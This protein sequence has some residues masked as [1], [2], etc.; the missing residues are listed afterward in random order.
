MRIVAMLL[1]LAGVAGPLAAQELAADTASPLSLREVVSSALATH[2]AVAGAKAQLASAEASVGEAKSALLPALSATA[3]LTRYQKPMIVAPLHALNVQHLPVFE[4]TLYEAHAAL[5][6]TIFDG[7]ARGAQI[8]AAE[9]VARSA[10]AGVAVSS[11]SVIAETV[12]SYLSVLTAGEV[13]TANRERVRALEDE[14]ARARLMFAQGKSARV[15]VLRA[16]AALSQARAESESAAER[17]L[18]ARRRLAR[19]SGLD[20][21]RVMRAAL[22]PVA[23]A[24][25]PSL[26][27]DT[28][29]TEALENNPLVAQVEGRVAASRAAVSAARSAYLP[30]L[31][32]SGV[33]SAYGSPAVAPELEGNAAVQVS[34]PIFTGGARARAVDRARADMAAAAADAESVRRQVADAVDQAILSY[35]SARAR[36]DALEAAVAQ[37]AE[38]ARVERL[39][40]EAGSGVQTDFLLAEADL[41]E[42]R[43][44]LAEARH[45]VLDA[46][47][48]LAR[49]TGRLNAGWVDRMV[50]EVER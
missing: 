45:A 14:H 44:S 12:S 25:V 26:E 41:L 15:E 29:L 21:T 5:A 42:A 36:V 11:E 28:L 2:P 7:G 35:R 33:Y 20:P 48:R 16:E 40:L 19:T 46:M 50:E 23:P 47:V 39:A 13:L 32:L 3:D 38:V 1:G 43:A 10:G 17:L 31:A 8:R 24:T 49:A 6:Y 30:Q 34:Y 18:L 27:R 9:D 4:L 37:S 22:V